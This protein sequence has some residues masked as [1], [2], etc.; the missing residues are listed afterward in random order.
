[1]YRQSETINKEIE[2]IKGTKDSGAEQYNTEILKYT[3]RVQ[4]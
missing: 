2:I 1:M 4:N 3:G